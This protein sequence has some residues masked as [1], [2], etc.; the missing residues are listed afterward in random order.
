VLRDFTRERL[1][2]EAILAAMAEAE[3]A[4]RAKGDFLANM[5]HEIRTPM[6]AIIGLSGL[7]LKNE[8]PPRIQD[9][10]SKIRQSGEHLLGIINDILDISKIESGK[11]EIESVPF[12]L[13]SVIN[14]VVNLI[15]EKVENQGLEL[16]CQVHPDVP[17]TLIGDPLRIGQIL[18]NLTSNAVKFT[19]KGEVRIG[20]Q[21]Q[22]MTDAQALILFR[23]Q[24]TGIGLP[25]EQMGKLFKSFEQADSSI[26][27]KYGGTG[28]G[29]AIS[30]SLAQAM[31]GDIGAESVLGEG[32]TFW[33]SA[34]LGVGTREKYLPL[35]GI[36]I[37]G[38]RVLVVDD[39]QASAQVLADTLSDIGFAVEQVHSGAA[40]L[41]VLRAADAQSKPYVFVLMDWQ[42]P[43]MDGLEAVRAIQKMQPKTA[44]FVLMVTA[45]R[46]QELVKAAERLG[47]THVLAKPVSGSML[48]NTMMQI[49]G[50]L[51]NAP[52]PSRT[53]QSAS[54][55]EGQLGILG[56]ARILLVEDNEINQM[57][58]SE[59]LQQAGL[60]V[61]VA[62]N[63]QI[64]VHQVHARSLENLPY[65][66]VLMDMQMP[67]MDGVS[68][69]RLIRE[70]FTT[71][72]LPIVAMTANAM[73]VDR[74]RCMDAGMN[75]V[76]TKPINPDELWKAL[77]AWVRVRP[78]MGPQFGV[79]GAAATLT[80]ERPALMQALRAIPHL[81]VRQGLQRSSDN[82]VF[83]TAM[84]RKFVHSQAE[85]AQ[86]IAVALDCSDW[87][88]AE[89]L[90]HTL[91]GV[92]GNLGAGG[93]QLSAETLE[94]ALRD[95]APGAR[96]RAAL[97]R[98][99]ADL[100]A[101]VAA[102]KAAPGLVPEDV[103]LAADALG[104]G[105][106]ADAMRI[107][108]TIKTLLAED[109][110][111]AQAQWETHATLLKAAHPHGAAIEAAINGFAFEK[112]LQL[113]EE[114]NGREGFQLM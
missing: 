107:F 41:D 83:Y 76:V 9:Y 81:D 79:R 86:R 15:S 42:M 50:R 29:L 80:E 98:T 31:G 102:L 71:A 87:A 35:A 18:I 19:E 84:L 58:A 3:A 60:Q 37:L 91:K 40:A 21:V 112:A 64:G 49:M 110:P 32:S 109:D 51:Q 105:D 94:N 16:L 93:V 69:A 10:L 12:E 33:F 62:D 6:N 88:L 65:D 28:L 72:Q 4:S 25:V 34:R 56:G 100:D 30:K 73:K 53:L 13:D 92:A 57:V 75:A 45:H 24:D 52:V 63:G 55:L 101:L 7:A 8:M 99:A 47:I 89:R 82:P 97:T 54:E 95:S 113:L 46:R 44:P 106:Y 20:I 66:L 39:N 78:G 68:A 17:H 74:D 11:M 5:S 61:D 36:D 67:V 85:V 43:G 22:E 1:A 70:H 26:T 103:S 96:I 2:E 90:A 111:E 38:A 27:R 77:L 59:L 14:N 108:G 48:V 104:A 114:G 23:V